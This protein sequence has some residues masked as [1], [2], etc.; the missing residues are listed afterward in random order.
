V[1]QVLGD[2]HA[3]ARSQVVAVLTVVSCAVLAF[4]STV[5]PTATAVAPT[6]PASLVVDP[7]SGPPGTSITAT[8][9]G[10][11]GC[12]PI[13][14]DDVGPGPVEFLWDGDD[15]LDVVEVTGSSASTT[16]VVPG[17]ASLDQ[18][19][20]VSRCAED[21]SRA[22]R[23]LFS[24]EPPVAVPVV[25]P[26]V[27]G[28]SRDEAAEE[29]RSADLTLGQVTGE[30]EEVQRQTPGA[31]IEVEPGTAV[32]IV[33]S[34]APP[35]LVVV[36]KVTG[37]SVD[38]ARDELASKGL[39]SVSGDGD[40]VEDQ[41]PLPGLEVPRGSTVDI[42]LG[43]VQPALVRV[44]DLIGM[45]VADVPG[46]LGERGLE[47]GQQSGDGD[48]VQG[49][50]PAPL[51]LVPPG[52]SVS[53]SVEPGVPPSPL[54]EVP[55]LTGMTLDEARASLGDAGLVMGNGPGGGDGDVSGQQPEPGTLVPAG[56]PV[57][58]ELASS[59]IGGSWLAVA[60]VVL[61][62]AGGAA[63]A[64]YQ[65]LRPRRDRRWLRRHVRVVP[66][67]SAPPGFTARESPAGWSPPTV[68]VRLDPHPDEGTQVLEEIPPR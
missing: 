14:N 23:T 24:V 28:F 58:L 17:S 33:M 38:E 5:V 2:R 60:A 12:P 1:C 15:P 63:L 27:V 45:D 18:H 26:N 62:L 41:S 21:A 61:A 42:E 55:D 3:D 64:T 8:A 50:R 39:G 16:F 22:A 67:V 66:R 68:V 51:S 29:L 46:K 65:S 54:V 34:A 32:D 37:R 25:V 20:V 6:P 7:P 53:I 31:G 44:P 49:Q 43:V 40:V 11:G 36:P 57:T 30:G 13:G 9:D 47:L 52:S 35:V 19:V 4:L 56:S 48:V 10:Y 59:G